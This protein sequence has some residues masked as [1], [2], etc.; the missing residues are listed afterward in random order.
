[1]T[2]TSLKHDIKIISVSF[3]SARTQKSVHPCVR[4]SQTKLILLNIVNFVRTGLIFSNVNV[5]FGKNSSEPCSLNLYWAVATVLGLSLYP[6]I[7]FE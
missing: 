1:M 6:K 2:L 5:L 4:A 7:K 3:G